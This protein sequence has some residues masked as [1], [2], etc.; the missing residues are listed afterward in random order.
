MRGF[1]LFIVLCSF[2]VASSCAQQKKYISYTVKSG[3]TMKSIA[4]QLNMKTKDL[5][6]LNPDVGRRPKP[7]TTIIIPNKKFG[8]LQQCSELTEICLA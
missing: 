5:L 1:K 6:R 2:V 3:E 8:I 4:N 7:N